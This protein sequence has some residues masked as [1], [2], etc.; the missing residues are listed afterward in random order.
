MRGRGGASVH[1][2]L[3]LATSATLLLVCYCTWSWGFSQKAGVCV[4]C[5]CEL[6]CQEL[7]RERNKPCAVFECMLLDYG[8]CSR[9][10]DDM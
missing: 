1:H 9:L 10:N 7:K 8:V 6:L 5:E 4:P 2:V 3:P